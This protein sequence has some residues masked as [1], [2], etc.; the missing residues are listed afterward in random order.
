VGGCCLCVWDLCLVQKIR[1]HLT[2]PLS[3]LVQLIT[4]VPGRCGRDGSPN[5]GPHGG[6]H[7]L[8]LGVSLGFPHSGA[9]G[10]SLGLPL[11]ISL[12][13]PDAR[14][15]GLSHPCGALFLV[16]PSDIWLGVGA[17]PV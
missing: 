4:D 2:I 14:P 1:A 8:P 16:S 12:G 17:R 3:T 9:L 15:D 10:V 13:V 6:S 5:G 7:G 11:G